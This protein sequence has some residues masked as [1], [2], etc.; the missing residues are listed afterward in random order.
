MTKESKM[1]IIKDIIEIQGHGNPEDY[2]FMSTER[3]NKLR[4]K[5]RI[6]AE[7]KMSG[8]PVKKKKKASSGYM[9]GGYVKPKMMGHGGMAY[10]GRTYAYG[11]RVSKYK[12]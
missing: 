9:G 4:S 12:G 10:R 1:S 7:K 6:D 5:V 3:L 8:G 11:G 2:N